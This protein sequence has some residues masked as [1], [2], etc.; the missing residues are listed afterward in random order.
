M[1]ITAEKEKAL[2]LNILVKL[3]LK[4]EDAEIVADA[5]LDADLKGFT[6]H[7]IGRFPQYIKGIGN[8]NIN[9]ESDII[10]EK[11]TESTG[12]INGKS[13]FGQVIAH[14]AMELA[15]KKS[16]KTGIGAVGTYN[17]NHFGVTGF[18][19]DLAIKNDV[20]GIVTAN[21]EP[22]IA[23]LGGKVPI[24]GTN[25][26]A[27]GIPTKDTYIA[28]DMATSASARGRLLEA[29]RK[30]E[31]IPG[32]IALDADGNPTTDPSKALEGSILPFGTHKGYAL[33]FMIEIITGPL[34]NAAIG[35]E[36]QGTA[37]YNK[38]C[39]KGDFF[40][41]IDPSKFVELNEFKERTE[42]FVKEIRDSG[43]TFIPGD[44]EVQRIAENKKNGI[45]IDD[46]LY[47]ELHD[48]CNKIDMNIDEYL[49]K[50]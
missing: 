11:E 50:K 16:K 45:N 44:L 30:G 2:V 4:K 39:T 18:Y 31:K 21:T 17:S 33:A 26:I 14:K 6:S 5:T 37:N 25:P 22:A 7:G 10:I 12:L 13:G 41:A 43:N 29:K 27:I 42:N 9:V 46:A 28:V 38:K 24:I 40:V 49:A 32:D 23:P 15:I 3:G 35:R 20:I 19:S 34:V 36:V 8:G 1:K 48:I 47:S